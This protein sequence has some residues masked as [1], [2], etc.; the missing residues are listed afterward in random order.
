ME[1]KFS[2]VINCTDGDN[3]ALV[4]S[5]WKLDNEGNRIDQQSETKTQISLEEA[6]IEQKIFVEKWL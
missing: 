1:T 3:Y 6:F 2:F 5:C 4:M